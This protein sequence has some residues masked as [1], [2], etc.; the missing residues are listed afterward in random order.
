[1]QEF[2][3][4]LLGLSRQAQDLHF[5]HIAL[6]AVIM[7]FA[8][9]L[10]LRVSQPR[11]LAQRNTMDTLL[12]L[13]LASM[14]ARAIN[15]SERFFE[16]IGAGFVLILL[17][18]LLTWA[19]FHSRLLGKCLKSDP[20][21]LIDDGTVQRQVLA[22]THISEEDLREDLR[23]KKGFDEF[24]KVEKAFLERNGEI[25]VKERQL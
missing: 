21:L 5:Q 6:R 23:L 2:L 10:M 13:L 1:M 22:H 8:V 7:F 24:D 14:L 9:L 11:F 25:S 15:G 20:K 18:R 17:H 19:S 16:T 3:V 4:N 12:S